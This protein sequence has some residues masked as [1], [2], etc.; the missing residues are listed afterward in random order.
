MSNVLVSLGANIL[1]LLFHMQKGRHQVSC[2]GIDEN[3]IPLYPKI[4]STLDILGYIYARLSSSL[5]P[6]WCVNAN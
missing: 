2:K 3:E 5:V 6:Q 1:I 4:T